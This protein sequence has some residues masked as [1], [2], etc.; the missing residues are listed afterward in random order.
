MGKSIKEWISQ[1]INKEMLV[2]VLP[3]VMIFELVCSLFAA[4]AQ[5]KLCFCLCSRLGC[6]LFSFQ[7]VERWSSETQNTCNVVRP[8]LAKMKN[9]VGQENV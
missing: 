7:E 1:L 6:P 8:E 5:P 2:I 4:T 3:L 9:Q